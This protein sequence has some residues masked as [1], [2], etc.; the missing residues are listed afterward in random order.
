MRWTVS[1]DVYQWILVE[2]S[3]C[4]S[5]FT[6]KTNDNNQQE[7]PGIIVLNTINIWWRQ[8]KYQSTNQKMPS[9]EHN[10]PWNPIG[11]LLSTQL[12]GWTVVCDVYRFLCIVLCVLLIPLINLMQ[13]TAKL[14]NLG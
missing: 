5:Y 8:V 14:N 6:A 9:D 13:T 4:P 7:E 11:W 1:C 10:S 12:K 2:C 3:S